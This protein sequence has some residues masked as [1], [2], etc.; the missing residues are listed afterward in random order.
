MLSYDIEFPKR[1]L[2]I[3]I[4]ED[5]FFENIDRRS[6]TV[7]AWRYMLIKHVEKSERKYKTDAVR[8]FVNKYPDFMISFETAYEYLIREKTL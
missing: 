2:K 4:P 8:D 5:F 6:L 1:V 3:E 7:I